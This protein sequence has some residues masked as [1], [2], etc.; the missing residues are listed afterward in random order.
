MT[1]S[2]VEARLHHWQGLEGGR[3][4]L[5]NLSENHTFRIDAPGGGKAVLRIHR[6][7]YQSRQAI[8]SELAWL[9]ALSRDTGL[10]TVTP[11]AGRDGQWLQE[12][13]T[14]SDPPRFAVLFAFEAGEIAETLDDLTGLFAELGRIAAI[15]H[16]HAERWPLPE[17]FQRPAWDAAAILEPDGRWGDWR[18]A[19]HVAGD[20]RA[21]L[22]RLDRRLR[23][24]FAAYGRD[25]R[26]FGLIHADMRL[27][28]IL[29]HAGETRLIDF[30][31]S[32][33]GWF[34]YDFAAAM[35]FIEDSP[36]LPALQAQWLAAY[37][38]ERPF[39]AEDE[40]ALDT[41]VMLRRMALL[42][43]I[44]SHGETE[45]AQAHA[46][47]FAAVTADLAEAYLKAPPRF[48]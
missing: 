4:T 28:N 14:V 42:A 35:S 32:G 7:G 3:A 25:S 38:R 30:D 13:Q 40:K 36:D 45:L 12:L 43:W 26:R 21:M 22:D 27:A 39:S 48:S 41:T 6:P 23:A 18:K 24:D 46:P 15:C 11:I 16:L 29:V 19:P 34:A 1:P 5:I 31:D 10:P 33:F 37:R 17:R 2:E 20:I 44:G 47:R 8:E 9:T